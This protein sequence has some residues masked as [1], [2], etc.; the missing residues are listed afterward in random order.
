MKKFIYTTLSASLI[1]VSLPALAEKLVVYSRAQTVSHVD[2]GDKG[3]S[4]GDIVLRTG[5]LHLEESGPSVGK[6][7]SKAMIQSVD[8]D[9][10]SDVRHITA[11]SVLPKGSIYIMDF[12]VVD[13]AEVIS[14]SGHKHTGIIIGG[15]GKYSGVRGTYEF[16]LDIE[17][18]V[19]GKF[20]Y[21]IIR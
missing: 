14:G 21:H 7:Y 20:V 11:E 18:A 6:F 10:K 8:A 13:M 16:Y 4:H 5:S 2:V 12:V 3:S 15:T 1:F 19:K 17:D 9:N